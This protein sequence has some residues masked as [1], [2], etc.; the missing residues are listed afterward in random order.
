MS[1]LSFITKEQAIKESENCPIEPVGKRLVVLQISPQ[2]KI[3]DF[4][5][6]AEDLGEASNRKNHA[7]RVIG[8]SKEEKGNYQVGDLINCRGDFPTLFY[9]NKEYL[10]VNTVIDVLNK[11]NEEKITDWK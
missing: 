8:V 4:E 11:I 1:K 10:I 9:N 5:I 3:G 2:I 7:F 6:E